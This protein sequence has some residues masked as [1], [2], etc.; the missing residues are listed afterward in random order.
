MSQELDDSKQ[1]VQQ[2][3]ELKDRF[4]NLRRFELRGTAVELRSVKV[5]GASAMTTKTAEC[6]YPS[7][8]NLGERRLIK[9]IVD[10]RPVDIAVDLCDAH[11]DLRDIDDDVIAL[12][13]EE[14]LKRT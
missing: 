8:P 6:G 12:L 13:R 2:L 14:L 4:D 9:R 5:G 3:T 10:G 11:Y 1:I 7:C